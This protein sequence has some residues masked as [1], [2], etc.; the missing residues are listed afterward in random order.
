MLKRYFTRI[1]NV[2]IRGKK[3]EIKPETDDHL[4]SIMKPEARSRTGCPPSTSRS[5]HGAGH[6]HGTESQLPKEGDGTT[7]TESQ[8][9]H[10]EPWLPFARRFRRTTE[11]TSP[12]TITTERIKHLRSKNGAHVTTGGR[13]KNREILCRVGRREVCGSNHGSR[14]KGLTDF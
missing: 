4:L 11:E 8:D 1:V 2:L 12:S 3:H 7:H 13:Q 6:G 10:R 14:E 5:V 9:R